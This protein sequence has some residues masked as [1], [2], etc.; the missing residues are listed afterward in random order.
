M[1]YITVRSMI[2]SYIMPQ[3]IPYLAFE[4]FYHSEISS[5]T[6]EHATYSIKAAQNKIKTFLK[7]LFFF[8]NMPFLDLSFTISLPVTHT[9]THTHQQTN[10]QTQKQTNTKTYK[11]SNTQTHKRTNTLT[12]KHTNI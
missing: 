8:I 2:F 4:F 12:H 1:V 11:H 6:C 9:H 10:T 3:M 5:S 7:Y